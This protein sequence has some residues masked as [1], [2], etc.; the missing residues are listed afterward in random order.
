MSKKVIDAYRNFAEL[1]KD[2]SIMPA[3]AP[4]GS[5]LAFVSG[6]PDHR[7]A[8][9]VELS[10]GKKTPLVDVSKLRSAIA[11]A[12]G[13]T[14]PGQGVPF[15]Y[16]AFVGPET[17]S[18]AIG[19]D[20]LTFN[21][22]SGQAT[23]TPT[24]PFIDTY[25]GLSAEARMTPRPFKRTVP[26]V[27]PTDAMEILSPDA[28]YLL[29]IQE[30]NVSVRST[31][32][33][34]SFRLTQDGTPEIEW[35]VDYSNP[36]YAALG[37]YSPVTNWSPD[38]T[39]IAA[40]KIDNHG[41]AQS[42]QVHYLKRHDEVVY[43]YSAKA[44]GILEK[45]TLYLLDVNGQPPVEIQ[46]G[47]T[48][49]TYP[50]FAG[51]VP[52]GSEVLVF[53]M[54]RDCHR[55]Q[56]LAADA[57]SGTV[58]K[59]FVEEG[60]SFVRIH[61]DIYFGRKLG[62]T[63]TSDGKHILW[64]SERDGWK[65]IYKYNLQGEL[66]AQLTS[67]DWPVD[68]VKRVIGDYIYFSA[69]SDRARPYDLHLCRVPLGGGNV[70][71]LTKA[72]GKHTSIFSPDGKAFVDT[73]STPAKPP[74]TELRRVDG[75]LL[76][77][78]VKADISKLQAVGFASPEQFSVKAADGKTDLWGVMFKP[79]DFVPTKSY[80]LIEYIYGGPQMAVA[81]HAFPSTFGVIGL[82][83]AQL[84]CICITLDARGTPERSKEFHDAC[85][86][87]FAANL[88]ADHA[89]AVRQLAERHPYIDITRVGITGGSWGGYSSF[90][91][92]VEQPSLYKAAVCV[93][94]G[95]DPYSS[96]LYE[97]YLGLPHDNPA[98]YS[99][100]DVIAMAGRVQGEVMIVC[101][102]SD[103]A[104]W[105]DAI[106]LSEVL[107][108]A[109]KQHEFVVQPEQYH[110]FDSVHNDYTDQKLSAFFR[111]HLSF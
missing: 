78:L 111:R 64:L 46:L 60:R 29:S 11:Q 50:V 58:R 53:Q 35:N 72:E 14:P 110:G 71:Q 104:T 27:D 91:C 94:P 63:L 73:Y 89:A 87:N 101:G 79:H 2:A 106:K 84:G 74:V 43:R 57:S 3:W 47:E 67:G 13:V 95:F 5:C 86:G 10:T 52:D 97:C 81:D 31:Y 99:S 80:P 70:Q 108:R 65:H 75:T 4:D 32:D 69:H 17:I 96:V 8:W 18:F 26:L 66:L 44:G 77:E 51:W 45:H 25:L 28:K 15:E 61:H 36:A 93:A 38:G 19:Q 76:T 1:L 30:R 83:L 41:V 16:F 56:L 37:L 7:E 59:L 48:R 62:L 49:N 22:E 68:E 42:P 33:G 92:L 103:H 102:T 9:R 54:S 23:K 82:R 90:R 88:A 85:S 40:Y 107:I 39:R 105:T 34:R 55:V 24:T 100:A 109:G 20:R 98:G 12:T 21:L 6:A